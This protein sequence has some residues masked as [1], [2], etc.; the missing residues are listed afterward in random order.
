[1]FVFQATL[2]SIILV[3]RYI[4]KEVGVIKFI[5]N[6]LLTSFSQYRTTTKIIRNCSS[7][8]SAQLYFQRFLS[9]S[10]NWFS[11]WSSMEKVMKYLANYWN[12]FLLSGLAL[13]KFGTY[14]TSATTTTTNY[15]FP[16][17][18]IGFYAVTCSILVFSKKIINDSN[19]NGNQT[20][21][22]NDETQPQIKLRTLKLIHVYYPLATSI[23]VSLANLLATSM[24]I[25]VPNNYA[26]YLAP[27]LINPMFLIILID[28]K[29][30]RGWLK[31][32]FHQQFNYNQVGPWMPN[33]LDNQSQMP[34]VDAAQNQQIHAASS[35]V[36]IEDTY[37]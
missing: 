2:I 4:V 23:L 15:Q 8:F 30:A 34:T 28:D 3:G 5:I 9:S 20:Q 37:L 6:L 32:K 24:D 33:N 11:T 35:D 22:L 7:R 36:I 27:A 1:M 26:V 29:N 10:W 18:I 31:R 17:L 13:G 25:V 14:L 12:Q 16:I 21:A 19:S